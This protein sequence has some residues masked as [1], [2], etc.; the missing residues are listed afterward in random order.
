M[1]VWLLRAN[2]KQLDLIAVDWGTSSLRIW[3][4][5]ADNQQIFYLA[6]DEGMASMHDAQA[7]ETTLLKHVAAH[8]E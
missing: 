1:A 3:G 2:M 8:N 6:S 4:L 5:G 7:F